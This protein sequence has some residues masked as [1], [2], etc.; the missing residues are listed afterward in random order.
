MPMQ[1]HSGGGGASGG[2][3]TEGGGGEG[4]GAGRGKRRSLFMK[5]FNNVFGCDEEGAFSGCE[6]MP[7]TKGEREPR[8]SSCTLQSSFLLN[9]FSHTDTHELTAL[10]AR[11]I[12]D[13]YTDSKN[14]CIHPHYIQERA[15]GSIMDSAVIT[16]ITRHMHV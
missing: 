2:G 13:M 11:C 8:V 5:C 10:L 4:W 14:T 15:K 7:E 9:S 6:M 3:R 16:T 12:H 1:A